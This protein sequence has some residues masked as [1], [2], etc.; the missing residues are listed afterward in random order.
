MFPKLWIWLQNFL[1]LLVLVL[2]PL[3]PPADG[4]RWWGL[5]GLILAVLIILLGAVVGIAGVR[6]MGP[7]RTPHPR[8]LA[9]GKLVTH[10]VY[11]WV[12]HPLYSSLMAVALGWSLLWCSFWALVGSAALILL[13]VAKARVEERYMEAQFPGYAGYR[14]RVKRFV[15]GVY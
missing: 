7:S 13:L 3:T 11:A 14:Q 4:G 6:A 2:G 5:P 1:C 10:G 9:E 8:P 12:R 15:P